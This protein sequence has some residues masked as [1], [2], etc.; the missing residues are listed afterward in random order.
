MPSGIPIS[1]N[2]QRMNRCDWA[3]C[4]EEGIFDGVDTV[5][6]NEKGRKN[7]PLGE[8]R[9][10]FIYLCSAIS[11]LASETS[12]QTKICTN[13]LASRGKVSVCNLFSSQ[14]KFFRSLQ[15][16]YRVPRRSNRRRLAFLLHAPQV[17]RHA[18]RCPLV[19]KPPTF[20]KLC[21]E[22]VTLM[23]GVATPN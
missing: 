13:D 4:F 2:S 19:D 18:A 7:I 21:P 3:D 11:S 16:V 8:N 15:A 22:C 9:S 20:I 6:L 17:V 23:P 5:L 12:S 14:H 10:R 1:E